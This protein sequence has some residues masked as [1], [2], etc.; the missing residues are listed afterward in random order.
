MCDAVKDIKN[1]PLKVTGSEKF[2]ID[3][4]KGIA[5]TMDLS[6]ILLQS[7]PQTAKLMPILFGTDGKL[8][9]R[10]IAAD[11]HTVLFAYG[12]EA[13]AKQAAGRFQKP[14]I[15]VGFR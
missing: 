9:A 13:H 15:N 4:T 10:L 2:E 3:G 11:E 8:T 1:S 7:D 12:N 5:I 6:G 14:E